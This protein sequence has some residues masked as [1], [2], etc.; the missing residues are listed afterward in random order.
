MEP[1]FPERRD[2]SF[3]FD[4][5]KR[6]VGSR[7]HGGLLYPFLAHPTRSLPS[8]S[9][10]VVPAHSLWRFLWRCPPPPQWQ[11]VWHK[12]CTQRHCHRSGR[13]LIIISHVARVSQRGHCQVG[14][15]A[16][17]LLES[18]CLHD[19]KTCDASAGKSKS[20]WEGWEDSRRIGG[21]E[22]GNVAKKEVSLI[23]WVRSCGDLG[24]PPHHQN[25][26]RKI[27]IKA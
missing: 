11:R 19:I 24:V 20:S 26:C 14:E 23:T 10:D 4:R 6:T 5:C 18:S 17:Q 27:K 16:G 21:V 22:S 7:W 8:P 15:G 13:L 1:F 12:T 2:S 3:R 25:P 9:K